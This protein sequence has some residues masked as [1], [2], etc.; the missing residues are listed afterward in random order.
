VCDVFEFDRQ[1]VIW[2]YVGNG[3]DG[4][5]EDSPVHF[6]VRMTSCG[7]DDDPV[8]VLRALAA[9]LN[10]EFEDDD[11]GGSGWVGSPEPEVVF[12]S[13][14]NNA[15][16]EAPLAWF[17]RLCGE[18]TRRGWVGFLE[19]VPYPGRPWVPYGPEL[20]IATTIGFGSQPWSDCGAPAHRVDG[21]LRAS[22][23]GDRELCESLAALAVAWVDEAVGPLVYQGMVDWVP[24]SRQARQM[25]AEELFRGVGNGAV[26][27][28]RLPGATT[29]RVGR[30]VR[31][32]DGYVTFSE[33]DEAP[34]AMRLEH[35]RE[36]LASHAPYAV[37]GYSGGTFGHARLPARGSLGGYYEPSGGSCTTSR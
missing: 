28:G 11:E 33:N 5:M 34:L 36:L 13:V 9:E 3:D 23:V 32:V 12:L 10:V 6:R 17:E 31:L 4:G 22:W 14:G 16:F 29:R 20:A 21:C 1:S 8:A 25:C 35:H 24:T 30:T 2:T 15:D 26:E 19:E 7:T 27:L 18:L 37:Y